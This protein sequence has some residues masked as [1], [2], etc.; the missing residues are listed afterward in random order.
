MVHWAGPVLSVV[1]IAVGLVGL[2]QTGLPG[3]LLPAL[4]ACL[5]F[6]AALFTM[7]PDVLQ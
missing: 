5:L 3:V 6:L 7:R 2:R 4:A 1:G